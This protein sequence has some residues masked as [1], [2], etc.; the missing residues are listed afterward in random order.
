MADDA[1]AT[2]PVPDPF[3]SAAELATFMKAQSLAAEPLLQEVLDAAL[4]YVESVV[5]P[6]GSATRAYRV[7]ATT[8]TIVLPFTHLESVG[9]ITDPHGRV[10]AINP[11]VDVNFLAGIIDLPRAVRGNWTIEA[12]TTQDSSS[13]KLAVMIIG[14]HLWET[15]RGG[16]GTPR[17]AMRAQPA[18]AAGA[19]VF[20]GYAIPHRAAQLLK[21]FEKLPG[22]A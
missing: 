5:G 16:G 10:V 8:R 21:P 19:G 22:I 12:T 7:Y 15:Q 14:S 1:P 3:V 4:E 9:T 13:V 11:N 17:D 20:R 18:P 2:A 6:L